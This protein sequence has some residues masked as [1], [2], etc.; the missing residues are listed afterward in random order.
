MI[1]ADYFKTVASKGIDPWTPA[2]EDVFN[3][4]LVHALRAGPTENRTDLEAATALAAL[5]HDELMAFGTGGG[6]K[7]TDDAM[8]ASLTALRAV[9]RRLGVDFEPPFRNF[10]SFKSYWLRNNGY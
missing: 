4:D 3:L 10:T 2:T 5:V 8:A 1:A 6:E 9:T 7:L